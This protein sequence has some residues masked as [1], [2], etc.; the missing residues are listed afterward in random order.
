MS[1]PWSDELLNRVGIK[2]ILSYRR[3][4]KEVL[5][6]MDWSAYTEE[7]QALI[8]ALGTDVSA[9]PVEEESVLPEET[10]YQASLEQYK[11]R[12]IFT[13]AAW[14][15]GASWGQLGL[16]FSVRKQSIISSSIK[17]LP[18]D[19]QAV[20]LSRYAP[21]LETLAAWLEWYKVEWHNLK[22]LS[23]DE[24]ATKFLTI[25]DD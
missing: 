25:K 14:L 12:R 4:P 19:R 18:E 20:R 2:Q 7:E 21:S 9:P 16:L 6:R 5:A 13:A 3:T 22:D 23:P 10:P 17:H 15:A 24:I 1:A 11:K 8:I